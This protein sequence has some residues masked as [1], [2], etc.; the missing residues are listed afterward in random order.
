HCFN[1]DA[2]A[3]PCALRRVIVAVQKT[4]NNAVAID[5]D[6]SAARLDVARSDKFK[7]GVGPELRR[8]FFARR[9]IISVHRHEHAAAFAK[10]CQGAHPYTPPAMVAAASDSEAK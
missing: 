4:R 9:D 2:A 1:H 8:G 7:I 10:D 3:A 6:P 5:A